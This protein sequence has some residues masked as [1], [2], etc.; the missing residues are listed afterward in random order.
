MPAVATQTLPLTILAGSDRKPGGLEFSVRPPAGWIGRVDA[1][2]RVPSGSALDLE[3]R[4]GLIEVRAGDANVVDRAAYDLAGIGDQHDLIVAVDRERG[5]HQAVTVRRFDIRDSLTAP[6][7]Y[8][9]FVSRGAL[10]ATW[11]DFKK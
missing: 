8:P 3:T 1:S 9:V 11:L 5:D 4:D 6:V 2:A 7:R 10:F